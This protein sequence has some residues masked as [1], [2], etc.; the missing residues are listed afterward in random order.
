MECG[1]K[2]ATIFGK[3]WD[4]QTRFIHATLE[5]NLQMIEDSVAFLKQSGLTVFFDAEHF[6]DGYKANPEYALHT[7][8]AAERGGADVIILCD[9]N[10]GSL[11][12]EITDITEIVV[13]YT[14]KP[15]GIHCHNDSGLAVANTIAAVNVCEKNERPCQI[16]GT[17]NGLGERAGNAN[18]TTIL[19]ILEL[20]M[21][22]D[23]VSPQKIRNLTA[24]SNLVYEIANI[25]PSR[26]RSIRRIQCIFS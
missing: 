13:Q 11:T 19:P 20:K 10:G 7:L 9:T 24:I 16:Q 21:K 18:L 2:F 5:E 14:A 23:V 4:F 3:S 8:D 1:L 26:R 25:V 6:F 17:M 22:L 12:Q 15:L